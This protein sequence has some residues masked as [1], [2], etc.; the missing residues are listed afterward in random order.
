[1]QDEQRSHSGMPALNPPSCVEFDLAEGRSYLSH[2]S[3][4]YM[5]GICLSS[6]SIAVGS[7]CDHS[8]SLFIRDSISLRACLHS[9]KFSPL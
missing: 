1:M 4:K 2:S 5:Q 7:H 9:Q 8:N 6:C 3:I